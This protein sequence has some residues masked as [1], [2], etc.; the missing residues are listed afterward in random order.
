MIA[1]P[2]ASPSLKVERDRALGDML[3]AERRMRIQLEQH[4]RELRAVL[5]EA[6][7][8][9]DGERLEEMRRRD[10]GI[11][12]SFAAENWRQFFARAQPRQW[13]SD[14]VT[15]A[16]PES[17]ARL[18]E[19][20]R[21]NA[22][23]KEQVSFLRNQ[24]NLLQSNLETQQSQRKEHED[25]RNDPQSRRH[26]GSRENPTVSATVVVLSGAT[27]AESPVRKTAPGVLPPLALLTEDALALKTAEGY[28][29]G[30][31]SRID[32][33]GGDKHRDVDERREAWSRKQLIMYLIGH[34]GIN[35]KQELEMVLKIIGEKKSTG[36]S[37][38]RVFEA[39]QK[40]GLLETNL[41]EPT[42]ISAAY[43]MYQ[44]SENGRRLYKHLFGEDPTES[45]WE[46]LV[47]MHEGKRFPDHTVSVLIFT[48]HARKRGWSTHV[49]PPVTDTHAMPDVLIFNDTERYYGEVELS[50]KDN[51]A[52]WSNLTALNGGK[53][54]I[55]AGTDG[56][57]KTLV[58]DCKLLNLPGVATDIGTLV[59][60]KYHRV[61]P[62]TPIWDERW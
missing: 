40:G 10:P 22:T 1:P 35:A 20:E 49:M 58:N 45:D 21:E 11:P 50:R 16:P 6:A 3:D 61:D 48:I 27:R 42:S 41:F 31:E 14:S 47:R 54:A 62:A 18:S 34:W 36:G 5:G 53:V 24:T 60:A 26:K 33:H 43:R 13:R 52:K 32:P 56:G 57:R 8:R 12:Q 17:L 55:I 9:L 37:Q 2:S 28:P 39:L 51:P 44:L 30:W 19:L 15:A 59:K 7:S 23:L 38:H 25:G 46:K 29:D 4:L